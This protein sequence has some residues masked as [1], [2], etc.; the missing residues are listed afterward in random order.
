MSAKNK[1]SGAS[2]RER[3]ATEF[4]SQHV[5]K[6]SNKLK[7]A[8]ASNGQCCM[9]RRL[10]S[11]SGS[12]PSL[13]SAAV[14]WKILAL[15]ISVNHGGSGSPF[16]MVPWPLLWVQV[17]KEFLLWIGKDALPRTL[18]AEYQ[19]NRILTVR[20]FM[21]YTSTSWAQGKIWTCLS[22]LTLQQLIIL[23]C[24]ADLLQCKGVS[25]KTVPM[26]FWW[27]HSRIL[28]TLR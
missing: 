1:G 15:F 25:D 24:W 27:S 21:P 13:R 16:Q 19:G 12:T 17:K 14:P 11:G 28:P 9:E 8:P 4:P 2:R 18:Q 6:A 23:L 26:A 10:C 5:F 22:L 7:S 20:H 3:Q